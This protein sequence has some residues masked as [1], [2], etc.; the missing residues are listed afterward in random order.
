LGDRR[1]DLVVWNGFM[2]LRDYVKVFRHRWAVIAASTIIA[3][4]VMFLVTPAYT[5][6]TQK[7]GSYT[8]TATLLVGGP[9][10]AAGA[11]Q[12]SLGSDRPL[13]HQRR[14][15]GRVPL[16]RWSTRVTRRCSPQ[17]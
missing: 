6:T 3:A 5:D 16:R 14:D 7:V 17:G 8:A 11:A 9:G 2:T 4:L 12:A 1:P 10:D 15:P 13:R